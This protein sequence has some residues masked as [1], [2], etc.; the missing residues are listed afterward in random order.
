MDSY[1]YMANKAFYKL[2]IYATLL[3]IDEV[4]RHLECHRFF[5]DVLD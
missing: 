1:S 2:V 4:T 5:A 3:R